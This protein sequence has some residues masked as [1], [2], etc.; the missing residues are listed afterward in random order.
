MD[1]NINSQT[2]LG[3]GSGFFLMVITVLLLL[4]LPIFFVW[5]KIFRKFIQHKRKRVIATWGITVISTPIILV[6]IM[7]LS[8]YWMNYYPKH[9]FNHNDWMGN[10]DERYELSDDIINSKVLIGKTKS[11]IRT[12]LGNE[13]NQDN[14]DEWTYYLG[15]KP[16]IL[17]IDPSALIIYFEK[18]KV[19][20]IEQQYR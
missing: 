6:G 20:R 10:K 12:L 8:I 16:E 2:V 19:T 18:G 3:L 17:N 7:N 14:L 5:R 15:I 4:G 1:F 11:D 9:S 13:G